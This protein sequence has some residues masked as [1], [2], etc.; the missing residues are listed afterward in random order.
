MGVITVRDL[1]TADNLAGHQ[2]LGGR[3]GLGHVIRDVVLVRT[4]TD[5]SQVP[6]GAAA[7]MDVSDQAGLSSQHLVEGFCRRLHGRGG[8]LLIVTGRL[9]A[10]SQSTIRLADRYALPVIAFPAQGPP[11]SAEALTARLLAIVQ[12]P[13]IAYARVLKAV[14][15][16]LA[17]A[18][19]IDRILAVIQDALKAE[20]ALITAE[21][22][23]V[24]GQLKHVSPRHV[25]RH[26]SMVVDRHPDYVF[27]ANPVYGADHQVWLA[28]EA[29]D[30]GPAW[31]DAARAVLHMAAPAVAAWLVRDQLTAAHDRHRLHTLF[32]ALLQLQHATHVPD[33]VEQHAA[34]AGI[35]LDGWHIGIHITGLHRRP[36]GA[37]AY[38]R[39]TVQVANTLAAEDIHNPLFS[40][41][42]GW[43]L[44]RTFPAEPSADR[45]TDLVARVGRALAT[46]N[47][48][49]DEAL[50]AG[51]GQSMPGPRSIPTTLAQAQQASL[52]AVT[53]GAGSVEAFNHLDA[54]RLIATWYSDPA[55]RSHA[56]ELLAPVLAAPDASALMNTLQVYL[57]HGSSVI[58]TAGQLGIH[59]NTVH[60]RISTIE[61]LLGRQVAADNLT[62]HLACLAINAAAGQEGSAFTRR[63]HQ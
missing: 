47:T 38:A 34:K 45:V 58:R 12:A 43:S 26:P 31:E 59:R 39:A 53:Q 24:H 10:V 52:V 20:A 42:E 33:Y 44:W 29:R 25:I 19:T 55:F 50:V 51:F 3:A 62:L 13:D 22:H 1:L 6:V 27:A 16:K 30:G 57:E 18:T 61:R 41:A 14:A 49:A 2:L 63:T 21:G 8:R 15:P 54:K 9:E 4:S 40:S 17:L 7:V 37:T 48:H 56:E 5:L 35:L 46:Y 28:C 32:T 36:L 11:G 60:Q 23:I